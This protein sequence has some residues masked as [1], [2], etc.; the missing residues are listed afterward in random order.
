MEFCDITLADKPIF[1]KFTARNS[2]SSYNFT[3]NY[4]W[5]QDGRIKMCTDE[6][7][8]Y[9][10]CSFSD[11]KC[12]LFPLCDEEYIPTAVT[13]AT[14]Y[15]KNLGVTP[16]FYGLS[17]SAVLNVKKYFENAF[18]FD[19]DRDN[20]DYVYETAKLISLSGKKLHSKKNHLNSFKRNYNMIYRPLCRDD[21]PACKELFNLWYEEKND[22]DEF[23]RLSRIATFTLL[24]NFEDLGITG[25]VIEVDGKIVACTLGEKITPDTAL[26]HVEFADTSYTGAYTAINNEFVKNEFADCDFINREEDMGNEGLRKAKTSYHPIKLL[27]EY[28]AE[29][30]G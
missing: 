3:T 9:L 17:E 8:L 1:D 16:K 12:M 25:G 28:T 7:A 15:L 27:N 5:G 4:I 13:K 6:G 19:Y 26:V 11:E 2:M 30:I 20:S 14:K 22:S 29:Y 23:L 24:E 21:I 18:R 10:L